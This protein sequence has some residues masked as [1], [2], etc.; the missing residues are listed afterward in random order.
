MPDPVPW[1]ALFPA[2]GESPAELRERVRALL[3]D[4]GYQTELP[5]ARPNESHHSSDR[6]A[7]EWVAWLVLGLFVAI[8]AF[9]VARLLHERLKRGPAA[10]T[11]RAPAPSKPATPIPR[12]ARSIAA[13]AAP[14]ADPAALAAAGQF[15]EAIHALLLQT[16]AARFTRLARPP[17]VGRTARELLAEFPAAVREPLAGLV[18]LV[19]RAE[20]AVQPLGAVEWAEAQQW[21]A[22]LPASASR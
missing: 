5:P 14:S 7:P 13:R 22:A 17:P 9:V 18:A 3:E 20:F 1:F 11:T 4:G 10:K 6:D 2:E 12:P 16:F 8:V 21:H 19:E 15:A